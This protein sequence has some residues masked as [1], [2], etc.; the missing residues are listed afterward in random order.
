MLAHRQIYN[1]L[2]PTLNV[3]V[4]FLHTKTE[5]IYIALTPDLQDAN[6][7]TISQPSLASFAGSWNGELTRAPQGNYEERQDWE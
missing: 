5:V 2:P 7:M 3:P 6:H 1:D 4:D